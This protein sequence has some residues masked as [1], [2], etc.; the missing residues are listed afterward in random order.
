MSYAF[1]GG[2]K[3]MTYL[4]R[5]IMFRKKETNRI[6]PTVSAPLGVLHWRWN[7]PLVDGE[8]DA[9]HSSVLEWML[10]FTKPISSSSWEAARQYFPDHLAVG[11]GRGLRISQWNLSGKWV[12]HP[13]L[14]SPKPTCVLT[15]VLY[16]SIGL[17]QKIT[18]WKAMCWIYHKS[19]ET[20]P[21]TIT[22]RR[23]TSQSGTS[24]FWTLCEWENNF[25]CV[26]Q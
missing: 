6:N 26:E 1:R 23:I 20:G 16:P 7:L 24:V 4:W 25:Y 11:C 8:K 10:A 21:W 13:S 18:A 9:R 19:R 17:M 14:L 15:Y 3:V 12:P 22:W 2:K 5:R